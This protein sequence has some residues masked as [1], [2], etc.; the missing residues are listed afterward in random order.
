[1]DAF[2]SLRSEWNDLLD[3]SFI[4]S[5]FLTWEWM[6]TWWQSYCV[7]DQ[8]CELCI[9]VARHDGNLSAL[10]PGYLRQH[11]FLGR[12]LHVFSFLGTDYESSD[13]LDMI[14]SE[15]AP[16]SLATGMLRYL[17]SAESRISLLVL[18]N[19][20]NPCRLI[21]PLESYARSHRCFMVNEVRNSCPYIPIEGDYEHFINGLSKRKNELLRKTRRMAN[22]FKAEISE[23][24]DEANLTE[25][26]GELFSLHEWR[27]RSE[28]KETQFRADVRSRFHQRVSKLFMERD[29]LRLLQLKVAGE[30]IA[31]IYGFEYGQEFFAYQTGMNPEWKRHSPLFVL[32][33]K[34]IE[35][36]FG[37]GLKRFD[38]MRGAHSYKWDW[39]DKKRDLYRISLP[40]SRGGRLA[41]RAQHAGNTLKDALKSVLPSGVWRRM[42]SIKE[43]ARS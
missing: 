29:I 19:M 13:Y 14:A 39:T 5:P 3:R 23:V 1:M 34:A 20:L 11:V 10:L 15:S 27:L 40:V 25:G 22:K 6:F 30:T 26:I 37:K 28:N 36:A 4:A 9:V 24:Q 21:G 16:A 8:D 12:R 35:Y 33:G 17:L 43:R 41:L 2:A 42:S 31:T 7:E 38:F 18:D 32:W